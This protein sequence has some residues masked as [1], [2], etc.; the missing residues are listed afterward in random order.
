VIADVL[1]RDTDEVY[2]RLLPDVVI[3]H[4]RVSL[5]EA[6][7]RAAM[8]PMYITEQEFLSLHMSD[9]ERPPAATIGSM[10]TG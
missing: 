5:A 6:R 8:R 7:R 10:W 9:H 1:T 2:R 3:V 4:L